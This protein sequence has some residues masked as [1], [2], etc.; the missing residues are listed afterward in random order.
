MGAYDAAGKRQGS[1]VSAGMVRSGRWYDRSAGATHESKWVCHGRL[2]D[3]A[4]FRGCRRGGYGRREDR[5]GSEASGDRRVRRVRGVVAVVGGRLSAGE[6]GSAARPAVHRA[7]H[8]A[9][10]L[11]VQ[12]PGRRRGRDPPARARDR[13]GRDVAR[14]VRPVG[15]PQGARDPPRRAAARRGTLRPLRQQP[16]RPPHA[17]RPDQR[18][19]GRRIEFS[20]GR[21]SGVRA[22]PHRPRDAASATEY[23]LPHVAVAP[24]NEPQW[25]W[26]EKRR[27]Q[28]G[29]H[30]TPA[31]AAAVIRAVIEESERRKTGFRIEAPESGAWKETLAYAQ[32]MFADPVINRHIDEIAIHSYWTDQPTKRKSA[33]ALREKFPDKLFAMTEFCQMKG[34]H[35]L[36][37]D[38]A[39]EMAEV[40][41]DDLT[42]GGVVSWQWWLGVASGGYKDGLLY[43][44]PKTQTIEPTKRLWALGNYS[45][46][47]RPGA[48]RVARGRE[49]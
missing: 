2:V 12:H 30:Y 8:R 18:G 13:Q 33:D 28:E 4:L 29:C 37:I 24:I 42:I 11:P 25:K 32:A 19:R 21:G 14:E 31:E 6:A 34:G 20:T 43:A 41:H 9:V 40:I 3:T 23:D 1:C 7:G 16:A 39:I 48:T 22:I 46:F 35:D 10:D 38:S 17:Q 45:R 49:R 44:H 5:P 36:G 26:G 47:V 15:R 27:T